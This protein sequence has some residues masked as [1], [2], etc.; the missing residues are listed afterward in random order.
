MLNWIFL[1]P[2]S[3]VFLHSRSFSCS[4]TCS[5]KTFI[6][7]FLIS[8]VPKFAIT[9]PCLVKCFFF[10]IIRIILS[11]PDEIFIILLNSFQKRLIIDSFLNLVQLRYSFSSKSASPAQP[12]TARLNPKVKFKCPLCS[13]MYLFKANLNKHCHDLHAD[14]VSFKCTSLS[15][16]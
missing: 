5:F 14:Q 2:V 9:C 7:S 8:G 15:T 4:F 3:S 11:S 6:H 12:T 16:T 13:N 1:I 10:Q